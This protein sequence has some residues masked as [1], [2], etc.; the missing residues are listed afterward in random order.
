M[1]DE[2]TGLPQVPLPTLVFAWIAAFTE[3]AVSR[4]TGKPQ[5]AIKLTS[6]DGQTSW[7][8]KAAGRLVLVSREKAVVFRSRL[9]AAFALAKMSRSATEFVRFATAR[10]EK[11]R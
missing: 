3:C 11:V 9:T 6:L 4:I 2:R 1:S 5:F 8:G 10:V 7:A